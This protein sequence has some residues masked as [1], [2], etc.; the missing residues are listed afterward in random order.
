MLLYLRVKYHRWIYSFIRK[1]S[2]DFNLETE[3]RRQLARRRATDNT[4]L[5]SPQA[6]LPETHSI[7]TRGGT[8]MSIP[9]R[10]LLRTSENPSNVNG[11][12]VEI[13]RFYTPEELL[14]FPFEEHQRQ[15]SE[16]LEQER[17]DNAARIPEMAGRQRRSSRHHS[18]YV[19]T[20]PGMIP[21]ASTATAASSL[22]PP[23]SVIISR[24]DRDRR[25]LSSPPSPIYQY[26][27]Q[28][29]LFTFNVNNSNDSV[30]EEEPPA[31][32]EAIRLDNVKEPAPNS[33]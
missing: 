6:R 20:G 19:T 24:D 25:C 33:Q 13:M 4:Y 28:E 15:L 18:L 3:T 27:P 7:T 32:E 26:I 31:Y 22:A 21:A 12:E 30:P 11:H 9:S 1:A 14:H 8:S 29:G 5:T 16:L 2:F 23:E 10:I 17:R